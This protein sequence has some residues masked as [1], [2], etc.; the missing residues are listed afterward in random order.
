MEQKEGHKCQQK[1]IQLANKAQ[2][3]HESLLRADIFHGVNY[4]PVHCTEW[5]EFSGLKRE[6]AKARSALYVELAIPTRKDK[7]ITKAR[8]HEKKIR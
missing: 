3:L 5:L 6:K 8:R 4:H 2:A 1:Q 7:L